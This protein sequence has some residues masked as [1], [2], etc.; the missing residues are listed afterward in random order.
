MSKI[1][2]KKTNRRF[3]TEA[4]TA[5]CNVWPEMQKYSMQKYKKKAW[6]GK[7]ARFGEARTS[8]QEKKKV[9]WLK[10]C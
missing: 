10:N 1:E 9:K 7:S 3:L 8:E 6:N 4:K 5:S 2:K